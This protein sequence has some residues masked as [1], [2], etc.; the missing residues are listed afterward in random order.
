MSVAE[1]GMPSGSAQAR[2]T[3]AAAA[4]VRAATRR[5]SV[6][7]AMGRREPFTRSSRTSIIPLHK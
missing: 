6:P 5:G 2:D 7:D 1:R 4:A 3:T